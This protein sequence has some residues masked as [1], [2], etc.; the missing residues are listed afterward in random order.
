[1]CNMCIDKY[2]TLSYPLD[3]SES[4]TINGITSVNFIPAV[5]AFLVKDDQVLL[6]ERKKVTLNLGKNLISG[7]GGK[8][9]DSEPFKNESADEA[10]VRELNEELELTP[11]KYTRVGNVKFVWETEPTWNMDVAIYI[12]KKWNGVPKE[13]EV[14]KPEWY[15]ITHLP[16]NQM[17]EDNKYWV[18]KIL[19]GENVNA[20]FYYGADKK[21][22]TFTI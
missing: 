10:L 9:G 4:K 8:I 16:Q 14:A 2:S 20:I 18:P 17:W 12:V 1:M 5:V 11:T 13:T 3:M 7:V 6:I 19:N 15:K 22:S 21:V